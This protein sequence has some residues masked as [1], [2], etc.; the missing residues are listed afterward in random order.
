MARNKK[1]VKTVVVDKCNTFEYDD[2]NIRI[3]SR[4]K[5]W[6]TYVYVDGKQVEN[7]KSIFIHI[8]VDESP[9]VVMNVYEEVDKK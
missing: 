7:V 4:G 2:R 8:E 9:T 3:V 5:G 1:Y 6:N